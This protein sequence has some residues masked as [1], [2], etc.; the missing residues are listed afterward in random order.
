[1]CEFDWVLGKH[2]QCD[3][4]FISMQFMKLLLLCNL[5]RD[6]VLPLLCYIVFFS[7]IRRRA[8][9]HFI[10]KKGSL[11]LTTRAKRGAPTPQLKL[12]AD[13]T[14]KDLYGSAFYFFI[15]KWYVGAPEYN[16]LWYVFLHTNCYGKYLTKSPKVAG[17]FPGLKAWWYEC[18]EHVLKHC[19][20]M[21]SCITKA[22][23]ES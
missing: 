23:A 14:A 16:C 13:Y 17:L 5:L 1:M 21:K 15:L 19:Y 18:L 3:H 20:C 11:K 10:K 7:R 9:Y 2:Q 8:V 6:R 22:K 4:R 12:Q